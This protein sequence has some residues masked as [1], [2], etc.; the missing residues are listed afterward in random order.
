MTLQQIKKAVLNGQTVHWETSA[1]K[2]ELSKAGLWFIRCIPNGHPI[3][4]T[5]ADGVTMNGR[6]EAFFIAK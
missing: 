1:Y 6:E 3:G 2:V 5:W 4:L